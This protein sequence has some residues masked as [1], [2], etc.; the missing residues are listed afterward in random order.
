MTLLEIVFFRPVSLHI[1][2]MREKEREK[3]EVG[4]ILMGMCVLV[5]KEPFQKKQIN[6]YGGSDF[7]RCLKTG[8][9]HT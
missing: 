2:S 6:I 4:K 9:P 5:S 1:V 7:F 8:C 3:E